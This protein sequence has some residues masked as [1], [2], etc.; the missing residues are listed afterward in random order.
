MGGAGD[1]TSGSLPSWKECLVLLSSGVHVFH[2]LRERLC[3][4]S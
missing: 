2:D 1:G 3:Y 4:P